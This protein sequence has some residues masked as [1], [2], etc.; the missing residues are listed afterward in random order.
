MGRG[1]AADIMPRK[2]EAATGTSRIHSDL[3]GDPAEIGGRS[4][5]NAT[6]R[7]GIP[8]SEVSVRECPRLVGGLAE[9][10]QALETGT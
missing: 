6:R 10:E 4:S 8:K 1:R 9:D 3:T 2:D 7:D 5:A